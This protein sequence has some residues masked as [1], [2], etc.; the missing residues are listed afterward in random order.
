MVSAVGLKNLYIYILKVLFIYFRVR[1][2]VSGE[3]ERESDANSSLHGEP[4]VGL[5]L[6]NLGSQLES[7]ADRND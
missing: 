5:D 7:E 2:H 1:K 3:R 6:T 4:D